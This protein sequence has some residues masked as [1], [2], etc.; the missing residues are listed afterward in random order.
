MTQTKGLTPWFFR[1]QNPSCFCVFCPHLVEGQRGIAIDKGSA[2]GQALPVRWDEDSQNIHNFVVKSASNW[3]IANGYCWLL[4]NNWLLVIDEQTILFGNGF[5]VGWLIS[6]DVVVFHV[7]VIFFALTITHFG[8]RKLQYLMAWSTWL[9]LRTSDRVAGNGSPTCRMGSEE[10]RFAIASKPTREIQDGRANKNRKHTARVNKTLEMLEL[11]LVWIS[12][13][14]TKRELWTRCSTQGHWAPSEFPTISSVAFVR[15]LGIQFIQL[16]INI[17]HPTKNPSKVSTS[18]N[19]P[20]NQPANQGFFQ[21]SD[22]KYLLSKVFQSNGNFASSGANSAIQ[23]RKRLGASRSMFCL[24][25][26][27]DPQKC[28]DVAFFFADFE[29]DQKM[30][31]NWVLVDFKVVDST[32]MFFYWTIPQWV[33]FSHG[34]PLWASRTRSSRSPPTPPTSRPWPQTTSPAVDFSSANTLQLLKFF[35]LG[36]KSMTL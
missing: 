1:K 20:T 8:R 23:S 36:K 18:T 22:R 5:I 4:V 34:F 17:H 14:V 27:K 2:V 29:F 13:V 3:W 10:P 33:Q 35:C 32:I 6:I 7:L 15:L 9:R 21:L 12:E 31:Q 25:Q 24:N 28:G 30:I 26:L 16:S 11:G 19:Q